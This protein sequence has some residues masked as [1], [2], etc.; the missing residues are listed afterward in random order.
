MRCADERKSALQQLT[1]TVQ[2]AGKLACVAHIEALAAG[3]TVTGETEGRVVVVETEAIKAETERVSQEVERSLAE[4][5]RLRAEAEKV[6]R[7]TERARAAAEKAGRET[8]RAVAETERLKAQAMMVRSEKI[9]IDAETERLKVETERVRSVQVMG[10]EKLKSEG[11]AMAVGAEARGPTAERERKNIELGRVEGKDPARS[12]RETQRISLKEIVEGLELQ[13]DQPMAEQER[14]R[15]AVEA[16][17]PTNYL[18]MLIA[19]VARKE[20]EAS[21]LG[22][23]PKRWAQVV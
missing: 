11:V 9:R 10:G 5:A 4:T 18:E 12:A 2:A 3:G 21:R 14:W 6:A 8:E 15:Q 13:T 20:R 1:L 17:R 23:D 7:E 19:E 16:P 22:N